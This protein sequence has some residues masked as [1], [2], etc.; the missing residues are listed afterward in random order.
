[1]DAAFLQ[2]LL[3]DLKGPV[4]RMRML[5][6]LL[7]RKTACLDEESQ[8][9]IT[10]IETSAASAQAV[11]DALQRYADVAG[12]KFQPAQ[13][14]LDQAVES[15]IHRL[16][17]QIENSG[18]AIEYAGLPA[19]QGDAEQIGLLFQELIANSLRFSSGAAPRIE[20][21]AALDERGW[22]ISVRDNGAGIGDADPER[23]FRPFGKSATPG[24]LT[25]GLAVCRHI[26]LLHGGTIA[27][28]PAREGAE[29]QL[30]LPV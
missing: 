18:A 13:F 17:S 26:A 6:E 7:C 8:R 20:I 5:G 1:M 19:V 24:K 30:H 21:T 4:S 25:I 9:L 27:A 16:K 3:H 28:L 2:I 15:A 10:H 23:I 29:F 22:A 12:M 11:L 14:G